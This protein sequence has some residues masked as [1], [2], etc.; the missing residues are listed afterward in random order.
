MALTDF[1]HGQNKKKTHN[2]GMATRKFTLTPAEVVALQVAE[3]TTRKARDLKR[4]QVV[5]LYGTG[6]PVETIRELVG[7]SWRSLMEW[8]QDYREGGIE[9]LQSH[10]QGD[11]A[12]KLSRAERAELKAKLHQYR[13][14]QV[15][16]PQQ[17][18]SQGQF[19]TVS[20]LKIV[21]QQWYAV[22]YRSQSSYQRLLHE[23]G[24]SQQQTEKQYRSRADQQT[25]ADF[26]AQLEKK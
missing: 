13:P 9:R 6:Y 5:R 4:L 2:R 18:I 24:L 23:C 15:L 11:N 25:V 8:C 3:S 20:D 12:L 26:E 1:A 17:R 10:W 7:G 22:S 16:A 14:D 21:V 19:W